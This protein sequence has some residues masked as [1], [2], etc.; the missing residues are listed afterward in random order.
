MSKRMPI[1]ALVAFALAITLSL[2]AQT[3]GAKFKTATADVVASGPTQGALSLSWDESGLG[4]GNIDYQLSAAA[5]AVYACINGGGNHPKAT[6]KETV[7]A[8]VSAD[9]SFQSKNGRVRATASIGPPDAGSFSCPSGQS[10]VLASVEYANAQINDSTSGTSVS[11]DA[12]GGFITGTFSRTF[13][14]LTP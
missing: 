14:D 9:V 7:N 8:T 12:T 2:A 4:N 6:N 3:S 11:G 5:N 10:L 1:T 13:F